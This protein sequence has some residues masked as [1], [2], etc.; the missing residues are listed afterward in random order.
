[1][2]YVTFS[3]VHILPQTLLFSGTQPMYWYFTSAF[4]RGLLT[5]LPMCVIGLFRVSRG[6]LRRIP[7]I[8]R[9]ILFFLLPAIVFVLLYSILPHKEL[10]FVMPVFPVFT[11]VAAVGTCS[12]HPVVTVSSL[13]DTKNNIRYDK[14]DSSRTLRFDPFK[15]ARTI[16]IWCSS[17][18]ERI[19]LCRFCVCFLSKLSRR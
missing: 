11:A 10:R 6:F 19:C 2:G 4:P 1:M 7:E 15:T 9:D 12:F 18:S 14:N 16:P 17:C 8:D 5:A 13:S 3:R